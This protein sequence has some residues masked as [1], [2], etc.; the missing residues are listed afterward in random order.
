MGFAF[1]GDADRLIAVDERGR[2]RGRRRGDGHLR[3][4]PGSREGT[5]RNEILVTTVMSNGG[6]ER[7]IERRPAAG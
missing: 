4:A 2:A 5:L 3:A 7:A 1:D 6:L